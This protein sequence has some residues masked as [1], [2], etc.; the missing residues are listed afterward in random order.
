MS[1]PN[2]IGVMITGATQRPSGRKARPQT[3]ASLVSWPARHF[4]ATSACGSAIPMT[5]ATQRGHH[6]RAR[7][8]EDRSPVGLASPVTVQRF[9]R[10][11][12]RTSRIRSMSF[13]DS[14]SRSTRW[15]SSLIG[16]PP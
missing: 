8:S 1:T 10:A 16:D 7:R 4:H 3:Q 5:S 2:A 12:A 6:E 15:V 11:R 14:R 13:F 9:F